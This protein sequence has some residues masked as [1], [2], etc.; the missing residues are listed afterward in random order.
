MQYI[1]KVKKIPKLTQPIEFRIGG[2]ED[3]ETD[4]DKVFKAVVR[5]ATQWLLGILTQYE[6]DYVKALSQIIA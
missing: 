6:G 1:L 5:Y 4:F 2:G 3:Y